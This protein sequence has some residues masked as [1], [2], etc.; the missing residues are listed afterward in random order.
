MCVVSILLENII[1]VW[2][3]QD[4]LYNNVYSY[5]LWFYY[6]MIGLILSSG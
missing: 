4:I 5:I 2:Q 3:L 1:N 6:K